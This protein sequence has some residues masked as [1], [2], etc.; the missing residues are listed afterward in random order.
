[1]RKY[2][3]GNRF[4]TARFA[5][6]LG[7]LVATVLSPLLTVPGFA[8]EHIIKVALFVDRGASD[9]SKKI[10]TDLLE[11]SPGIQC[12]TIFG[13]DIRAGALADVDVLVVPGGSARKEANSM[14]AD[15]RDEVRRFVNEGGLYMGVCAGAY[16]S[17]QQRDQDLGLLPLTTLDSQHW[18]RVNDGTLVDVELTPAGMD[19]FGVS[20]R[21]IKLIYENGPIFAPPVASNARMEPLGFYRSE[22]VANGGER[23]VMLGAPSMILGRYGR[24]LVLAISPHPEK[25]PGK[26]QLEL[27]ALRWLYD[28]R[29]QPDNQA[30]SATT[31][32]KN[33]YPPDKIRTASLQ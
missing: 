10:F 9:T 20:N 4:A 24:G 26:Q 31:R 6:Q 33:G 14:G 12:K 16:L 17:S 7:L 25:T 13:E 21:F 11:N 1:M 22:V 23:G 29:S 30:N 15:S 8:S 18:Y 2:R 19:I 32:D 5:C 3:R 28:H 27:H